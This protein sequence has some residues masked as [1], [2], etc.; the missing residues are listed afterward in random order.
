[1]TT[2]GVAGLAVADAA[3]TMPS[4]AVD[5]VK[6]WGCERLLLLSAHSSLLRIVMQT[7]PLAHQASSWH[8]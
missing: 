5:G 4:S 3:V 8:G 1:V 6:G 7:P 2:R